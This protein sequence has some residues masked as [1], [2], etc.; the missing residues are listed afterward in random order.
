MSSLYC[1]VQV[2]YLVDRLFRITSHA[3]HGQ[4]LAENVSIAVVVATRAPTNGAWQYKLKDDV[5]TGFPESEATLL[6]VYFELCLLV[7]IPLSAVRCK[8]SL[9]RSQPTSRRE[10]ERGLA[11]RGEYCAPRGRCA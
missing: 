7:E 11:P 9:P 6:F 2:A 4:E 3:E 8:K 10:E 1:I 5:W